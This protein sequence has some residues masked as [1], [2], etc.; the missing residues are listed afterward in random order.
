M[1]RRYFDDLLSGGDYT[2]APKILHPD[3]HHKDMVRDIEYRGVD[4]IV[5][6]M[7]Q[8]KAAYPAF[9][10]HVVDIAFVNGDSVF[11]AF[12]GHAAEGMPLFTGVDRFFFDES[13]KIVEVN[14]YR[15]NW[16]GAQGHE[17]RKAEA[18]TADA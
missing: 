5:E 1:R 11:V 6:Y 13:G 14:V 17:Q 18:G 2:L 7:R 3:V 8:V 15:S 10:A 9:K 16:K 4:E 12:E